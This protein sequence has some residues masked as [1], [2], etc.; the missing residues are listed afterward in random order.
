MYIGHRIKMIR[1]NKNIKQEQIASE[2]GI[3]QKQYSLIESNQTKLTVA[4]MLQIAKLIKVE[5]EE[6]LK[7]ES[8][9]QN[10]YNNKE[11]KAAQNYYE[12]VEVVNILKNEVEYL[13]HQLKIKDDQITQII[14]TNKL[15]N[16]Q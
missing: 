13:K 12:N 1:E 14:S 7:P 2:L 6:L 8:F 10:N 15:N 5:P 16:K 11:N 9:V 4:R 3:S